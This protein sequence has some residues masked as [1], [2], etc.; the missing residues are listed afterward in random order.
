M[1]AVSR[2]AATYLNLGFQYLMMV[3]MII[4]G[5][6]IPPL[7]AYYIDH[8]LLGRSTLTWWPEVTA[9]YGNL[10]TVT[11]LYGRFRNMIM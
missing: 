3:L 5:I 9:Q 6:V 8:D 2:K 4:R 7:A 11:P 10:S 1:Q